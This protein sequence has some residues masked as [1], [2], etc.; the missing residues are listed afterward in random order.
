MEW[1]DMLVFEQGML[2]LPGLLLFYVTVRPW[3]S[4][5]LHDDMTE[6]NTQQANEQQVQ[7]QLDNNIYYIFTATTVV[8]TLLR[9]Q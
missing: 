8:H 5:D 3:V 2:V 6:R 9:S 7:M 1:T 4:G